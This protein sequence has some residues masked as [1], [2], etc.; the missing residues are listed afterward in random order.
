M[1]VS[2]T[3]IFIAHQHLQQ[4]ATPL[5]SVHMTWPN[6]NNN[7]TN[8]NTGLM[9]RH[10]FFHAHFTQGCSPRRFFICVLFS[11]TYQPATKLPN[12]MLSNNFLLIL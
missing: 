12:D 11:H 9:Y 6:N 4:Q 7:N 1:F 3:V 8:N 5:Q 10:L 2:E